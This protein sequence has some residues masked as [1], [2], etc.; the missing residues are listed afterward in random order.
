MYR[1]VTKDLSNDVEIE[2]KGCVGSIKYRYRKEDIEKEWD[3]EEAFLEG[4]VML[5]DGDDV[6]VVFFKVG[7][8]GIKGFRGLCPWLWNIRCR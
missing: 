5:I 7:R 1:L 3:G 6:E 2:G 4:F 8:E